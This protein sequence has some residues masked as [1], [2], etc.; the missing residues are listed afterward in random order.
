VRILVTGA[1]GFIGRHLS[2]M[3]I[4]RGHDY[5]AAVR[6]GEGQPDARRIAVGE[7]GPNTDWQAALEGIEVVVHLAARAHVLREQAQDPRAEFMRI[8]AEGTGQLMRAA[9]R[10]GV[11]RFIYMSTIGVHGDASGAAAITAN[12]PLQPHNL[13]ADSKLAG[14]TAAAQ[15]AGTAVAL[16]IV[17]PPLVYGSGVRAN[18]LRILRWVDRGWPAPFGAIHN[19]RSLVSVW[20]LTDLLGKLC[21]RELPQRQAWVVSDGEPVSTAALVQRLAHA[22]GR[23]PRLLPV[24]A[25]VLRVLGRLSGRRAELEALCGSLVIDMSATCTQLGWSPP[26]TLTAGLERTVRWYA[27]S[28]VHAR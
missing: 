14:E 17:R 27:G 19:Q 7:I 25:A 15:A 26:L 8:N 10:A 9:V 11:R 21:E 13:Y 12:S 20:N 16:A 23:T 4:E 6:S 2:Q 18:F 5:R 1:D 22:M 3:L 28:K 24:P